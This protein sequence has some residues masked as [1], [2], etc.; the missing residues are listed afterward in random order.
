MPIHANRTL[1]PPPYWQEFEDML[2]DLFKAVWKDPHA[3]KNGRSGQSQDGVDIYGQPE[4]RDKWA[5]VQA[6]KKDQL[7]ASTV[8]EKE[9]EAEVNKAKQFTPE[10]SEFI[11]ATTG[12]RDQRIQ[13][14]TRLLT[15]AHQ[16]EG[17]FR[18]Y[19]YSWEDIQQL[20]NT[21]LDVCKRWYPYLFS[22]DEA[23]K[24]LDRIE[25][26]QKEHALEQR[27]SSSELKAVLA[28]LVE[29][30]N[31]LPSSMTVSGAGSQ[32]VYQVAI[33]QANSL[34]DQF[35]PK[36]ALAQLEALREKA[37]EGADPITKWKIV[38]NIGAA[39][40]QLDKDEEAAQ[41][42]I[43]AAQ[44]N[45]DDEKALCNLALAY[46][47]LDNLSK[48]E[49]YVDVV[50]Q[51]NAANERAY[52]LK[53]RILSL[54]NIDF[55]SIVEQIPE[56]FRS[57]EEIAGALGDAAG[58]CGDL[59][60]CQYWYGIAYKSKDASSFGVAISYA[61]SMLMTIVAN[62]LVLIANKV[63]T[64]QKT[65][66]ENIIAIYTD[67]YTK[68]ADSEH[69]ALKLDCL[70]NRGI[71]WRLVG[72]YENAA[73]DF[74]LASELEPEN[75]KYV[76]NRAELAL[77]SGKKE[78]AISLLEKIRGSK[79]YPAALLLAEIYKEKGDSTKGRE[80]LVQYLASDPPAEFKDQAHELLIELLIA[81]EQ[82]DEADRES[83]ALIAANQENVM[84][85]LIRA[86][87]LKAIGKEKEA[88]ESLAAA[89]RLITT[90]SP[91]ANIVALA[92]QYY[93][94]KDFEKAISLYEQIADTSVDTFVTR[95][96]LM[97]YYQA[98]KQRDALT[99]CTLLR[100]N[101]GP[102]K[103]ITVIEADIYEKIGNLEKA[104]EVCRDYLK[105]YPHDLSMQ[106][107]LALINLR[108]QNFNEVD[109]FLKQPHP[110]ADASLENRIHLSH[111]L[112]FRGF[113]DEALDLMYET[114]RMFFNESDAHTQYM[115]ILFAREKE[116]D[117]LLEVDTVA[118]NTAVWLRDNGGGNKW[119]VIENRQDADISKD[120]LD[121]T[122]PLAKKLLGKK[123]GDRVLLVEG[124]QKKEGT[125]QEIKSKYVDALHKS[126]A[127][128]ETVF[129]DAQGFSLLNLT[130]THTAD[131]EETID[132]SVFFDMLDR[133]HKYS[134]QVLALYKSGPLTIGALAN[135]LHRN[136][137]ET[138]GLLVN[139]PEIGVRCAAGNPQEIAE[140]RRVLTTE[141]PR[142]VADITTLMTLHGLDIAT[143]VVDVFG[144]LAI[145][146]STIDQVTELIHSRKGIGEK[147]FMSVE[148]EGEAYLK[149]EVTAEQIQK[150]IAYL[151]AIFDWIQDN[152]EVLPCEEALTLD[153]GQ[154]QKLY[155]LFGSDAI[156]SVLLSKQEKRIFVSEDER[157][158]SFA[159]ASYGVNGAWSQ[160]LLEQ[161][162][163][164]GK[165]NNSIYQKLV[166]KLVLSNYYYTSI[167]AETLEEAAKQSAWKPDRQFEKVARVLS[168]ENTDDYSA[169][170]VAL[171]FIYKLYTQRFFLA[172]PRMLLFA[173]LDLV[174]KSRRRGNIL[175]AQVIGHIRT[176]FSLLPQVQLEIVQ[177]IQEWASRQIFF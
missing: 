153:A 128:F 78:V 164:R 98:G 15:Q 162:L 62:K 127:M 99:I 44:Y 43:E 14:K 72:N 122:H 110:L 45:R 141:S 18:V 137:I 70:F 24:L 126:A 58:K 59:Q 93:D 69:M 79:V 41:L 56:E 94:L 85:L 102:L 140:A 33:D 23:L 172:D 144:K 3:Q 148:K 38:T 21:H 67:A 26:A 91:F 96:L 152:C 95:N 123:V 176:R 157:L 121:I 114:R 119:Y 134:S 61:T 42:F 118:I 64:D 10:L 143:E 97:C 90:E 87:V 68:I 129:P 135:L 159:K 124:I 104:K 1:P 132:L 142:L 29:Q 17:L 73:K 88:H 66:L 4:Q 83:A 77:V 165:I 84:N 39:K 86:K 19:V 113:G 76:F 32:T 109:K 150:N 105:E 166:I 161:L 136:P 103:L 75:D 146:Q 169:V 116:P 167:S 168:D 120:E 60:K 50:L 7:A 158:R 92:N 160:A 40:F 111:L 20:L 155:D 28:S 147:G 48:A 106:I 131:G 115:A 8:T 101:Y 11:L 139:K 177:V 163:N 108:Q 5:G 74:D 145:A 51:K 156:D 112:G 171:D 107:R 151:Q 35:K 82:Y 31:Y 65:Q 16:R 138:W 12:Q 55:D 25:G 89:Q 133:Q 100:Q 49:Q 47:L 71:A 80:V 22:D 30:V 36:T 154:R 63:S 149:E 9:L 54:R 13:E 52:S 2:H 170:K 34:L 130:M 37:W 125:I 57:F 117:P 174:F 173:V 81:S 6:K 53:V 46:L 27:E 175:L